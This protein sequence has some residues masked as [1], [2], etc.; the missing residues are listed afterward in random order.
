MSMS[1]V[2]KAV[3]MIRSQIRNSLEPLSKKQQLEV[4]ETIAGQTA[5]MAMKLEDEVKGEQKEDG[6]SP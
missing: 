4:L 5:E 1:K 6:V 2:Q 3:V